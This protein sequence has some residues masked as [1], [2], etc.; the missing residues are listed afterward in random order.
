[1]TVYSA[2]IRDWLQEKK[3]NAEILSFEK[4]VHSVEETMAVTGYPIERI[5]KSIVM[6]TPADQLVIAVVPAKYRA[7]TERV[8]KYLG[9]DKRPRMA[10]P[11]EIERHLGQLVGGNSPFNVPQAKI[12]IDS[13]LFE[14][15][16]IITGGGDDKHLV[17]ISTIDLRRIVTFS[18]ARVRK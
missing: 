10:T 13:K 5:T 15:E 8:R 17:K 11:E 1:M 3:A 9:L 4:S 12:L 2:R 6:L 7:S 16:W 18:E 14:M